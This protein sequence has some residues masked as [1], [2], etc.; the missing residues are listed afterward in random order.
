M[1]FLRSNRLRAGT[2]RR[3]SM[4]CEACNGAGMFAPASPSCTIPAKRKHWIVVERCDTCDRFSDDLCAALSRYVVAGW[5]NCVN[6][7]THALA[8]VRTARR[9]RQARVTTKGRGRSKVG[10]SVS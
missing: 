7:V 4:R 10:R 9:K 2:R 8:D 1:A 5:F 3:A 6:G